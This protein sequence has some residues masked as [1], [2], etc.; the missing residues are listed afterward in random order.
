MIRVPSP[1]AEPSG[2][3]ARCRNRGNAWLAANPNSNK[4][5]NHWRM[6]EDDLGRGFSYRCGW[7][8]MWID[9]GTVDHFLP[10]TDSLHRAQIYEWSNYRYASGSVNSSKREFAVLD[11]FEVQ[12]TWFEVMIPSMQLIL[13]AAVPPQIRPLAEE[14]LRRLKLV[15][16]TKVRRSRVHWYEQYRTGK[17]DHRSL[18]DHAPLVDR[19]VL[20]WEQSGNP[21][22]KLTK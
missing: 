17:I 15:N 5:P 6:F 1:V 20:Q 2:F 22:P 21:L 19:A 11:P 18:H 12:D 13:T 7:T 3:D 10:K 14:T 9:H 16:G 4:Y 8:A